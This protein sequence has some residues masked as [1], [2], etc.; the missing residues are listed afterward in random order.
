MDNKQNLPLMM[1]GFNRR[2]SPYLQ[3]IKED[4]IDRTTPLVMNYQINTK[5][6][7]E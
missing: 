3:R 4:I 2:F 1:T 5:T 7:H 6:L